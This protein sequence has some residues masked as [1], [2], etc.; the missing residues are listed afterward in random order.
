MAQRILNVSEAYDGYRAACEASPLNAAARQGHHYKPFFLSNDDV[1]RLRRE[2]ARIDLLNG[3]EIIIL[4][5]SA[6]NGFPHTR[7]KK[8]VC[9][10]DSF[11]VNS[12]DSSLAN[13]LRHEAM[14][15]HQRVYPELWQQKCKDEGWTPVSLEDIPKRF[16]DKCRI[17][18]DTMK[19]P[20]WAWDSYHVPLPMFS[21]EK[22][23]SL[24]D[25]NIEWFDMRTGALFH[26]PPPSFTRKYGSPSQP[27]H[28]YEIYAV[29]YADMGIAS[30]SE[31]YYVL[32]TPL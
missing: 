18:P 25:V 26:Q 6:D 28:P 15:I 10:P 32:T 17:N 30:H 14:H 31:L 13:T 27:E 5:S 3:A 8:V 11:V 9:L 1:R 12:T 19:T 23:S 29:L 16:R 4:H 20:F 24:G 21:S 7:P 22:P 2:I